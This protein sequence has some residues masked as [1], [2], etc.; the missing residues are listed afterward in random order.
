[1]LEVFFL[2]IAIKVNWRGINF[3]RDGLQSHFQMP[4]LATAHLMLMW[5]RL[6]EFRVL[7][8]TESKVSAVIGT[9]AF[10]FT[11]MY[12][13]F[14]LEVA[15]SILKTIL[16][17]ITPSCTCSA[18]FQVIYYLVHT[19]KRF[20]TSRSYAQVSRPWRDFRCDASLTCSILNNVDL[21]RGTKRSSLQCFKYCSTIVDLATILMTF[22]ITSSS[23][24]SSFSVLV[25]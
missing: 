8:V 13:V 25:P 9:Q 16:H 10:L 18:L 11:A 15:L 4:T 19:F 12:S 21:P 17:F 23:P 6:F 2:L 1:M 22:G 20:S 5:T 7:Q 14:C 24:E 3:F